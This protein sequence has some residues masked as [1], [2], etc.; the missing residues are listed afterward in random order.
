MKIIAF[1]DLRNET[2]PREFLEWVKNEQARVFE[3]QFHEI[4][5]F[6]DYRITSLDGR[7]DLPQM[8]QIFDY[9]GSADDWRK[10]L[11]YFLNTDNKELSKIIRQW[12]KFCD[13]STTKIIYAED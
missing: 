3:K 9:E 1:F 10:T 6:R 2:D 4:K 12:H 5:N 8:V 13:D 7:I 11:K